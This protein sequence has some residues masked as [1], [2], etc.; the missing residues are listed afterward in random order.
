MTKVYQGI[1]YLENGG[2]H[3][4][5]LSEYAQAKS[6][7][8]IDSGGTEEPTDAELGYVACTM[9]ILAERW[10][11]FDMEYT[12]QELKRSLGGNLMSTKRFLEIYKTHCRYR[13]F[14]Y[15]PGLACWD[16]YAS[17]LFQTLIAEYHKS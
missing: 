17:V 10:S 16:A 1:H 13:T 4:V 12:L 3:F 2:S 15:V 11:Y 5:L 7:D 6:S 8:S 14:K 9:L